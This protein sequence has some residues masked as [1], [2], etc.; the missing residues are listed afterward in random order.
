MHKRE[1]SAQHQAG[2]LIPPSSLLERAATFRRLIPLEPLLHKL[3]RNFDRHRPT[4]CLGMNGDIETERVEGRFYDG[5]SCFLLTSDG[6]MGHD[7]SE[8]ME[9]CLEGTDGQGMRFKK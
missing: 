3:E 2:A 6:A 1:L 8:E 5:K 9:R 4:H 7:A